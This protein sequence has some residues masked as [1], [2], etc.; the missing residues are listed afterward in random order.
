M[1]V[2]LFIWI[3]AAFAIVCCGVLDLAKMVTSIRWLKR[4]E[5][6]PAPGDEDQPFIITLLPVLREQRLITDTLQ[7][8]A[9]LKYPQQRHRIFVITTEKELAQREEAKVRLV[10]LAKDIASKQF[11][12]SFLVEK[13][14]GVFSEDVLKK[15]LATARR[16]ESDGEIHTFL[17]QVF[18]AYPTTIDL[19]KE[20]I[21]FLNKQ[22]GMPLFTHLHCP[23]VDG[24]MGQQLQ[25]A[26]EQL[27]FHFSNEDMPKSH[28][29][30]A[31]YNADSRPHPDTFEYL[32]KTCGNYRL[33][34][35]S[36]PP[37][38]QQSAIF[39]ENW[40][41]LGSSLKG[42][43]LQSAAILQTRWVMSHEIPRLR[44]QSRGALLFN[45]GKLKFLQ[46]LTGVEFALCVGHGS[47][48]RYD[49]AEELKLFSMSDVSDDLLWS[50]RLCIEHIPMLPLPILESAES[51]TTVNSLIIQKRS[52]FL[53]YTEYFRCRS[54][55]LQTKKFKR[56][57]VEFVTWHGLIRAVKW[58]FLSPLLFLVFVLPVLLHSWQ[59][60]FIALG[61]FALYGFSTYTVILMELEMLRKKSGGV[62]SPSSFSNIHKICIVTFSLPAFLL[63]S[64]GPWWCLLQSFYWTI[65]RTPAHKQK[66]ER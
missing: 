32:A 11:S 30:L 28:A 33:Q 12:L 50:F 61:I 24:N 9:R 38:M 25:Y 13:Y 36:L 4:E 66:T 7:A 53:G 59:L 1:E 15:V 3:V 17:R 56:S 21:A 51:P 20:D 2:V 62:W 65:T 27:P 54:L 16:K 52:W 18:D 39:L 46:R 8:F 19:V 41:N 47:F 60:L 64:L 55:A 42:L 26:V 5:R 58:L 6:F 49:L 40:S 43:L 23:R 63:E 44:R 14:L 37:I 48:L 34:H 29:Y 57:S 10:S 35:H 22:A 31:I 45:S